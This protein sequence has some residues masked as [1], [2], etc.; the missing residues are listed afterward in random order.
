M[1]TLV[2]KEVGFKCCNTTKKRS[3]LSIVCWSVD[4]F[5][6][7]DEGLQKGI[8]IFVKSDLRIHARGNNGLKF[9]ICWRHTR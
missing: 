3:D 2:Y 9:K 4:T 6:F 8:A 1:N 7:F 5:G